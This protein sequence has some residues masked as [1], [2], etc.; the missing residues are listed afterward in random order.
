MDAEGVECGTA[1]MS[2]NV[3]MCGL[4]QTDVKFSHAATVF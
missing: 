1:G 2:S 3:F 4:T